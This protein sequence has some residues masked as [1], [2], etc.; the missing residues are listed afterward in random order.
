VE[1]FFE[2]D[3]LLVAEGDAR[4]LQARGRLFVADGGRGGRGVLVVGP[5]P[6]GTRRRRAV[7]APGHRVGGTRVPVDLHPGE[8]VHVVGG[9][10]PLGQPVLGSPRRLAAPRVLGGGRVEPLRVL[11]G[12]ERLLARKAEAR[13]LKE[14]S[15]AT[16][17]FKRGAFQRGLTCWLSIPGLF[18]SCVTA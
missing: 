11:P 6:S 4:P 9:G 2:L 14:R 8:R 13:R 5:R 15:N 10:S 1:F 17:T 3:D 7:R 12:G 18:H 16:Q